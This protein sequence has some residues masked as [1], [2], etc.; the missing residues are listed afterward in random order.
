MQ[1]ADYP[2]LSFLSLRA[3]ASAFA[4]ASAAQKHRGLRTVAALVLVSVSPMHRFRLRMAAKSPAQQV[5]A[6]AQ[7]I[8]WVRARAAKR[9][10]AGR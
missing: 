5:R 3:S 4:P 9:E 7:G 2:K 6:A 8:A 1:R 10:S